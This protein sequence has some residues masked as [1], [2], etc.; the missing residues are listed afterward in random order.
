M[1]LIFYN[2]T[3]IKTLRIFYIIFIIISII[4]LLFSFDGDSSLVFYSI[5]FMLFALLFQL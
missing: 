1:Y 5:Y 3:M 4:V 2:D